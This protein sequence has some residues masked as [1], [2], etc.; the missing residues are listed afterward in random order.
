MNARV[1]GGD[2][3]RRVSLGIVLIAVLLV[4]PLASRAVDPD[5]TPDPRADERAIGVIRQLQTA[6]RIY[7]QVHGYYD[8]LECLVQDA[9]VPLIPYPPSYLSPHVLRSTAFGYRFRLFDGPRAGAA[10]TGLASSTAMQGYAFTAVPLDSAPGGRS[11]CGDASGLIYELD[12]RT[13][14]RVDAGRCLETARAL[15]STSP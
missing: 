12:G 8:R 5:A 6:Q 11:F 2:E 1:G 10:T 7:H 15:P 9:C 13:Q 3:T 14:P 4:W